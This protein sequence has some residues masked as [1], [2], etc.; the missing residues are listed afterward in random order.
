MMLCEKWDHM[1]TKAV[2]RKGTACKSSDEWYLA[3]SLY[4]CIFKKAGQ[5]EC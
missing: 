2:G 4:D 1:Q 5:I 3:L